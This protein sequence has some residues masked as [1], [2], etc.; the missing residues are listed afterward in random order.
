P[1]GSRIAFSTTINRTTPR[2]S[3]AARHAG[4]RKR[5]IRQNYARRRFSAH[6]QATVCVV[7]VGSF[8]L[9]PLYFSW[10]F[11]FWPSTSDA[12]NW[13]SNVFLFGGSRKR[14]SPTTGTGGGRVAKS[15]T[16]TC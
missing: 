7:P 13:S 1:A 8:R 10:L 5:R 3:R 6:S 15:G 4:Y 9:G 11:K 2:Q 14:V 12:R 16:R